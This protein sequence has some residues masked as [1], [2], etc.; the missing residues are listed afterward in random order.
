LH[1]ERKVFSFN[2]LLAGTR[3]QRRDQEVLV[4]DPKKETERTGS[5]GSSDGDTQPDDTGATGTLG[6][7]AHSESDESADDN[8]DSEAHT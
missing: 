3:G 2:A 8:G 5:G 4:S 1:A 7:T 6:D